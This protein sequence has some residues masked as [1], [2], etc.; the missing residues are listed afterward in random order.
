MHAFQG[1]FKFFF[2]APAVPI[3]HATLCL[4]YV[5]LARSM[6][7][8]IKWIKIYW[9]YCLSNRY[10]TVFTPAAT[11]LLADVPAEQQ[12]NHIMISYNIRESNLFYLNL[13]QFSERNL[14]KRKRQK[15]VK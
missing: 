8:R 5:P 9:L 2:Q 6:C 14:K 11:T 12:S 3:Y 4:T 13:L 7:E 1:F 15:T 10:S